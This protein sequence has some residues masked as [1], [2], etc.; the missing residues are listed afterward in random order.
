MFIIKN[1]VG[2]KIVDGKAFKISFDENGNMLVSTQ[3]I[4]IN[5]ND[6]K[7]SYAEMYRKLNVRYFTEQ[8]KLAPKQE[9]TFAETKEEKPEKVEKKAKEK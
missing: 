1:G 4:E 6:R 9:K 2:Y 8:K 7:Y 5:N 3:E